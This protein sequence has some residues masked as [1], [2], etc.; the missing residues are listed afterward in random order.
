M[1]EGIGAEKALKRYQ[2]LT[3]AAWSALIGGSFAWNWQQ[4]S[5]SVMESARAEARSNLDRDSAY[6]SWLV[7]QGGIYIR[8]TPKIPQDPYLVHPRKNVITTDGETLTL[9]NPAFVLREVQANQADPARS[10]SRVISVH[11]LNPKNAADD[12]EREGLDGLSSGLERVERVETPAGPQLRAM[13]P[14]FVSAPCLACHA[15]FKVGDIAGAI[16]TAVPLAPYLE[17]SIR[18]KRGF[19]VSH[20]LIWLAGLAGIVFAFRRT[21]RYLLAEREWA[22]SVAGLNAELEQR[23]AARTEELTGAL[24]E[25]ESFS[26]SVSHDLRTPLRALNGYAHL[27]KESLGEKLGR[28]ELH[29]LNRI[30]HNAE[31]MG[32]LIDDI[33]E[34]SRTARRSLNPVP[35]DLAPMVAELVAEQAEHFPAARIEVGP[36]PRVEGDPVMLRQAFFNL[37]GNALKFSSGR[38]TPRIEIGAEAANG[39]ARCHVRDNGTGFDMAYAGKLFSLFQR[40]HRESEYPGTGVGLAIVKRIVERHGGRIW[41]EA[42]PD[43]GATFHF[44]LPLHRSS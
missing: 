12:W 37:I 27:L 40:L 3:V 10:Q 38:A 6:R 7:E 14:F 1:E 24:R 23:V 41:A 11:P 26:Y 20:G 29:L 34:Y 36:L 4:E 13:R 44:T 31:K 19:A 35:V 17:I 22:A 42:A 9:L 8:P 39:M 28:E 2:I 30:A 18:A 25:I 5:R 33:L 16:S 43:A 21:R 32:Q 15:G